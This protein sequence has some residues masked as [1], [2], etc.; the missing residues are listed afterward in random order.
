L[1][2]RTGRDKHVFP[3]VKDIAARVPVHV[4]YAL[5]HRA[6]IDFNRPPHIAF[7]DDLLRSV[8]DAYHECMAQAISCCK[9]EFSDCVL[10]D[11]HGCRNMFLPQYGEID[12]IFGTNDRASVFSDIDLVF[13]EWLRDKGYNVLMATEEMFQG[14]FTGRYNV[15]D[16]AKRFRVDSIL[17]EITSKYREAGAELKGMQLVADISEFLSQRYGV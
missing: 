17:I 13:A 3:I 15:I 1:D 2:I 16:Y 6:F 4:I 8:Y 14:I 12:L 7:A 11:F 10:L 5:V 9:E